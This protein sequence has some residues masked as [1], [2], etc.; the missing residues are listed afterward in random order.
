MFLIIFF[1][2][3]ISNL[4]NLIFLTI[5]GNKYDK[6]IKSEYSYFSIFVPS[7][8]KIIDKSDLSYRLIYVDL[9]CTNDY[10]NVIEIIRDALAIFLNRILESLNP[11]YW[12]ETI[13]NLP[14][15]ALIYLGLPSESVFIKALQLIWWIL[16]PICIIFRDKLLSFLPQ[17]F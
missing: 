4:Y 3:I 7:F 8:R 13:I 2:K 10:D 6:F 14:K 16:A 12:I 11:L 15:T 1:Y 5:I 9:Y 17:L